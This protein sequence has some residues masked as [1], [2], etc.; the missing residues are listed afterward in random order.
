MQ[1][2]YIIAAVLALFALTG[3]LAFSGDDVKK[4]HR[5][6]GQNIIFIY[7]PHHYKYAVPTPYVGDKYTITEDYI[8]RIETVS[9]C[10]DFNGWNY[11]SERWR[12]HYDTKT[13][14]WILQMPLSTIEYGDQ[15][16]IVVNENEWQELEDKFG[17]FRKYLV[18]NS[19]DTFNL[20]IHKTDFMD[21]CNY[22]FLF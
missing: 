15:Y 2:T 20:M 18:A 16:K 11:L 22:F 1:I 3:E 8:K 21:N 14:C 17:G 13:K 6:E 9:I 19:Y 10:G 12:A 5:I 7:N 4:E